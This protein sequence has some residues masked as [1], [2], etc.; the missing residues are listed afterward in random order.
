MQ[1]FANY[2]F[3]IPTRRQLYEILREKSGCGRSQQ[4]AHINKYFIS[5]YGINSPNAVKELKQK[6]SMFC[7][8]LFRRLEAC[9]RYHDRFLEKNAIWLSKTYDWRPDLEESKLNTIL[10]LH[11]ITFENSS[12]TIPKNENS[13]Y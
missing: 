5:H 2:W 4:I 9:S 3:T 13:F 1:S 11:E 7:S 6:L 8:K 12:N 10:D